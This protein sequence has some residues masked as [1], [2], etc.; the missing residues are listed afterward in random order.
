MQLRVEFS[1]GEEPKKEYCDNEKLVSEKE[2]DGIL[3]LCGDS[4]VDPIFFKEDSDDLDEGPKFDN[5]GRDF[6]E[7]KVVFEEGDFFIENVCAEATPNRRLRTYA[8]SFGAW[9]DSSWWSELLRGAVVFYITPRKPLDKFTQNHNKFDSPRRARPSR[10]RRPAASSPFMEFVV[11]ESLITD[12]L[13]ATGAPS[14][15]CS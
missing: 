15:T 9:R 1:F 4:E 14:R 7:D 12:I 13:V 6:V 5:D 11:T 2:E 3:F 8:M 10:R